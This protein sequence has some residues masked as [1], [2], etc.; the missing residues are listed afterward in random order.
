MP[1]ARNPARKAKLHKALTAKSGTCNPWPF[2]A[3]GQGANSSEALFSWIS[4]LAVETTLAGSEYVRR[5]PLLPLTN[6]PLRFLGGNLPASVTNHV[7]FTAS[8]TVLNHGPRP[9]SMT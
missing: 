7:T 9:L 3:N 4:E 5:T 2:K 6:A 1:S 8:N